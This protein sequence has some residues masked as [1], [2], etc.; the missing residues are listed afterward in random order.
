[1]IG[2]STTKYPLLRVYDRR[3]D[4]WYY[5]PQLRM[6]LWNDSQGVRIVV[7]MKDAAARGKSLAETET[8]EDAVA[9]GSC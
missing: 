7:E 2:N 5:R 1:M 9:A 4:W 8:G 3:L 6:S